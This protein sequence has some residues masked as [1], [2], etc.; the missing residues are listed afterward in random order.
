[1]KNLKATYI[2]ISS[3][4]EMNK[5][6]DWLK[7]LEYKYNT[8][9]PPSF[10]KDG[11]YLF[12]GN[13][14]NFHFNDEAK[15]TFWKPFSVLYDEGMPRDVVMD[16]PGHIT[17][18]E[19]YLLSEAKRLYPIGTQYKCAAGWRHVHT[20][21]SMDWAPSPSG[22]IYGEI[23]KGCIYKHGKWAEIVHEVKPV[24]KKEESK[25]EVGKW[26]ATKEYNYYAK[27]FDFKSNTMIASQYRV[28]GYND[29]KMG[30][31]AFCSGYNWVEATQEQLATFLPE[32]HPDLIVKSIEKWSVGSYVVFLTDEVKTNSGT[33]ITKGKPYRIN[34]KQYDLLYSKSDTKKDFNF[35]WEKEECKWFAT[36]EEAEVFSKSLIPVAELQPSTQE[37]E[38]KPQIGDWVVTDNL[39]INDAD[40]G[41]YNGNIGQ[42][43]KIG[44]ILVD[45]WYK[46]IES[47]HFTGGSLKL[48]N[49]RKATQEEIDSMSKTTEVKPPEAKFQNMSKDELL[50]YAKKKYPTGCKAICLTGGLIETLEGDP[51]WKEDMIVIPQKGLISNGTRVYKNQKWAEIIEMPKEEVQSTYQPIVT[52]Y[53]YNG[54]K[55]TLENMY[56]DLELTETHQSINKTG[57]QFSPIKVELIKV[58]QLKIN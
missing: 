15:K 24:E 2:E 42:I 40:G 36:L 44:S 45:E 12:I 31:Y 55:A 22:H 35:F 51:Y 17:T 38:W 9:R 43:W 30:N 54:V 37:Q 18:N 28:G 26:Y 4:E 33:E 19:D 10:H 14:N 8:D 32:G 47:M 21:E 56:P 58:K 39:R 53:S 49:L 1:M 29:G 25:F 41:K 11:T 50:D 23:S 6:Y 16:K 5:A 46:P 7:S 13:T 57:K 48:H 34:E 3:E 52:S 27:C 20:V